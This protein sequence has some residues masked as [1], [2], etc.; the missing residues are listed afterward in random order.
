MDAEKL[1]KCATRPLR[2]LYRLRCGG[3]FTTLS[4]RE[5]FLKLPQQFTQQFTTPFRIKLLNGGRWA[6]SFSRNLHSLSA[7]LLCWDLDKIL[8]G[9]ASTLDPVLT[10]EL[11]EFQYPDLESVGYLESTNTVHIFLRSALSYTIE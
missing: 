9:N 2:F 8:N 6:I 1:R 5:I 3:D 11:P 4:N 10:L 7:S